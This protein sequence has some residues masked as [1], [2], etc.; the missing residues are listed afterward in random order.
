[1]KNIGKS[2]SQLEG[3]SE[4][5]KLHTEMRWGLFSLERKEG[6]VITTHKK[7]TKVIT[8][9]VQ[10]G[11]DGKIMLILGGGGEFQTQ[12]VMKCQS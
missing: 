1:M 3:S 8:A 7:K 12:K 10:K 9:V 2:D 4:F 5:D 6:S 11:S